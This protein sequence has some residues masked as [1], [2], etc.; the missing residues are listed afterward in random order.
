[1][2]DDATNGNLLSQAAEFIEFASAPF[3]IE[4]PVH[5]RVFDEFEDRFPGPQFFHAW[6]GGIG[7]AISKEIN[8][9]QGFLVRGKSRAR[10]IQREVAFLPRG[11]EPGQNVGM[12]EKLGDGVRPETDPR[13]ARNNG[14]ATSG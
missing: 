2:R 8:D 10:T 3:A 9:A 13:I 12:S 7:R 4:Q 11:G 6:G 1:M 5:V 14:I